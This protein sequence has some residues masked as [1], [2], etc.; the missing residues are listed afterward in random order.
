MASV[1]DITAGRKLECTDN[2]GGIKAFYV[3]NYT[4]DLRTNATFT[5]GEIT[6]LATPVPVFKYELKSAS[7]LSEETAKSVENGT[8]FTTQT[9]T[10]ILQKQDSALLNELKLMSHGRPQII[11][12]DYNGNFLLMGLDHGCGVS[13]SGTTGSSMGELNGYTLTAVATETEPASFIDPTLIDNIAGF[14]V[15]EGTN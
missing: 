12:E 11:V 7:N 15:T 9:L 1:C 2:V 14:T 8:T 6:A 10:A 4:A 3:A 5:A 13:Y